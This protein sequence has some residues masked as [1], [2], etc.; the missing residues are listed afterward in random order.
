MHRLFN[1][2]EQRRQARRLLRLGTMTNRNAVDFG[3]NHLG[4]SQEELDFAASVAAQKH[5]A[6]NQD[7]EAAAAAQGIEIFGRVRKWIQKTKGNLKS[8]FK[9]FDKDGGGS[10]TPMELRMALA[11]IKISVKDDDFAL[12][13]RMID[14]DGNG[15][16]EFVEFMDAVEHYGRQSAGEAPKAMVKRGRSGTDLMFLDY[17]KH[18][19]FPKKNNVLWLPNF[20]EAHLHRPDMEVGYYGAQKSFKPTDKDTARPW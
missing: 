7:E 15:T 12:M 3:H 18:V 4:P 9:E 16:V 2:R 10:L 20:G 6:L 1:P 8:A 17:P 13:V 5:T 19:L 11:S 14:Q